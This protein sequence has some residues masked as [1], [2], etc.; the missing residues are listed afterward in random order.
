[1]AELPGFGLWG[2]VTTQQG[3]RHYTG[4]T[5]TMRRVRISSDTDMIR[6]GAF[7]EWGAAGD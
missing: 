7:L 5:Y 6:F 4:E 2:A 1:V 3:T